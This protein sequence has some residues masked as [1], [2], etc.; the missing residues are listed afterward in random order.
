MTKKSR[1][2]PAQTAREQAPQDAPGWHRRGNALLD[3]GKIDGAITAFRRALRM[4]DKLAPVHN[5]LGT[6]YFQK[7]WHAEAEQS[8]RRAIALERGHAIAHANLGAAL[9]AQGRLS[10]GRRAFQRALVLRIRN[11]LP[12]ALRWRLPDEPFP[13]PA[14]KAHAKARALQQEALALEAADL[15]RAIDRARAAAATAPGQPELHITLAK[16]LAK[17]GDRHGAVAAADAALQLDPASAE[18]HAAISGVLHPWWE[19]L[20]EKAARRAVELD[21]ALH[22]GQGNLAAALWGLGRL[23][24]AERHAR[25]AIRLQPESVPYRGNLGLILKDLGKLEEARALFE[26]IA[27]EAPDDAKV[28]L[29][30]GTLVYEVDGDLAGARRWFRKAQASGA[31]PRAVLGEALL[32]FVE[33][34]LPSAWERYEARKQVPDQREKHLPFAPLPAW[35]GRS[36][37]PVLIYGEQGLGDEIMFASMLAELGV[38]SRQVRLLCDPRLEALFARSFPEY[39]VLAAPQGEQADHGRALEGIEA[40]AA[41]GSV[42]RW[43]RRQLSDFPPRRGY[44]APDPE[45]VAAWKARLGPGPHAGASWIGGVQTTGRARRSMRVEHLAPLLAIPGLQWVS[46]Q[47]GASGSPLREFPNVT[48]DLDELA[49]LIAALDVVVSVCNTTV[50]LAGALGKDVLVM[51]PFMPEWRYA[52]GG[53]RMLWYPSVRIFRQPRYGDWP[54]VLAQVRQALAGRFG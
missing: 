54:P 21:P 6:A 3:E 10:E 52:M 28:A 51:A 50:H 14:A 12:R 25:E 22:T 16:L 44:L 19:E 43:L 46:L 48:Q 35:D 15:P 41:A 18:I 34:N 39:R 31:S 23:E 30:L 9:R 1:R 40:V 24:E 4:D 53:E 33:G 2:V 5:D 17:A 37:V 29:D 49:A 13:D 11:M 45:K 42:G 27:R 26:A 38:R 20:A 7:G 47:H 32:D 36:D 8:F